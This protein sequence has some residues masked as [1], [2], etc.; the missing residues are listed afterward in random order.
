MVNNTELKI[1][2]YNSFFTNYN[3]NSLFKFKSCAI[4]TKAIFMHKLIFK[5]L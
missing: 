4:V 1:I 2:K 3:Y 5:K